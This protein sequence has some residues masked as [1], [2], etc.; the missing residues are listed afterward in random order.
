MTTFL[1]SLELV[2]EEDAKWLISKKDFDTTPIDELKKQSKI[3]EKA[4]LLVMIRN[5]FSHN[6]LPRKIY[7]DE[8][9][10]NVPNAVSINFNE[11]FLEYTNQTILEFK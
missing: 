11:L 10:K 9:Y 8:I 5:K 6:Q 4:F 2:S 3:M 7:Y 1:K